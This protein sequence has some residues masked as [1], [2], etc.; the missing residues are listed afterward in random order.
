MHVVCM[1]NGRL[2]DA[3]Y[4][5]Q[6]GKTRSGQI[7]VLIYLGQTVSFHNLILGLSTEI[8]YTAASLTG[9]FAHSSS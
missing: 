6:R 7:F 9:C 4:W 5:I 8:L 1:M 2:D 3:V